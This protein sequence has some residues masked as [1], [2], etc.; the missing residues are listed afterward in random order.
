M[1]SI[2][3]CCDSTVNEFLAILNARFGFRDSPPFI[4]VAVYVGYSLVGYWLIILS[5][6]FSLNWR[7]LCSARDR[8]AI[9]ARDIAATAVICFVLGF[10]YAVSHPTGILKTMLGLIMSIAACPALFDML[11]DSLPAVKSIRKHIALETA[12][13]FFL[14]ALLATIALIIQIYC[15]DKSC[16]MPKSYY[17]GFDIQSRMAGVC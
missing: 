15:L 13:A 4:Y 11:V 7:K 1:W 10:I 3:S 5:L 8:I 2:N 6:I 16:R 12:F 9:Y 14:V 17:W